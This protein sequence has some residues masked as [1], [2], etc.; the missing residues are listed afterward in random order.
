MICDHHHHAVCQTYPW[1]LIFQSLKRLVQKGY[2][3]NEHELAPWSKECMCRFE[4][5]L[6]TASFPQNIDRFDKDIGGKDDR[7][8]HFTK[9]GSC[10][11]GWDVV[12][13]GIRG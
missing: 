13:I 7:T 1:C 5:G 10:F 8:G 9:P 11:F 3:L 4:G 6:M 12:V 2:G